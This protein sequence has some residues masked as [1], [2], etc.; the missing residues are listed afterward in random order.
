MAI[1]TVTLAA[2]SVEIVLTDAAASDDQDR[3]I[4]LP[5]T[6]ESTRRKREIVQPANPNDPRPNRA[7]RTRARNAF[8]RALPDAH[9]WLD[10]LIAD[11]NVSIS[12]LAL[13]EHKSERSIRLILSLAFLSPDLARSAL[14][15]SLPRGFNRSRLVDLPMLWSDQWQAI[16]LQRPAARA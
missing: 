3:R 5:W 6:P 11:P 12:G 9:R 8:V 14:E 13:R 15:G 4:V 10:E 2:K 7:M 1:E 16:G